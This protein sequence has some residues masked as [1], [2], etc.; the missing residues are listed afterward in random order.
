MR[1]ERLRTGFG[2]EASP[3]TAYVLLERI[4]GQTTVTDLRAETGLPQGTL[5]YK[6]RQLRVGGYI[7]PTKQGR[8]TFYRRTPEGDAC[9]AARGYNLNDLPSPRRGWKR[10]DR[11]QRTF[12]NDDGS[13]SYG[14][15]K[16]TFNPQEKGFSPIP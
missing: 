13:L 1:I 15:P 4:D 5:M 16:N 3:V 11:R 8:N 12:R 2:S 9:L 14:E 6:L 7:V 10:K